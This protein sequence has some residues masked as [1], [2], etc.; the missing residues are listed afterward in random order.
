M[1]FF[2]QLQEECHYT[3]GTDLDWGGEDGGVDGLIAYKDALEDIVAQIDA[4]ARDNAAGHCTAADV[5]G[6][7]FGLGLGN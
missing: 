6:V 3:D 7:V 5:M 4:A 2:E 1:T